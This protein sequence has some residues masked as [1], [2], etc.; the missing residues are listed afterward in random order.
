[1][2]TSGRV[3]GHCQTCLK[4]RSWSI[5]LEPLPDELL[6]SYLVRSAHAHGM[7]PMH[8]VSLHFPRAQIW[9]RDI[10]ARAHTQLVD[11]IAQASNLSAD[12]VRSMTLSPLFSSN[13]NDADAFKGQSSWLTS[14]GMHGRF[15]SRH[16]LQF[17]PQCL[18][19]NG[20]FLRTWRLSFA[21]ACSVH[22][23]MLEN[24][25]SACSAPV[26]PHRARFSPST[27][28]RCGSVLGNVHPHD[29]D[30]PV[31]EALQVQEKFLSFCRH[32]FI[33]VGGTI[34]E[35][36]D[37]FSGLAIL[38]KLLREKM[39]WH[40]VNLDVHDHVVLDNH[41]ALRFSV[42]AVRLRLCASILEI[43]NRWPDE[44]FRVAMTSNMTRASFAHCGKTPTWLGEQI[45]WLPQRLR[46]Q[47]SYRASTLLKRVREIEADGGAHCR[48]QRARELMAAARKWS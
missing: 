32:D 46:R 40:Q 8:F 38:L 30:L 20:A 3:G 43:L 34:V 18:Q 22:H 47:Y 19:A 26:V 10:D 6:S 1:M 9:T 21:F 36:A 48:E 24:Q 27:C 23:R 29:A 35:R 17:C 14:I 31:D 37:F 25:C 16:G 45:D 41:E 42:T 15:R 5:R 2:D 39:H 12:L 4:T 33:D 7:H 11:A 13:A 28:H 44:F